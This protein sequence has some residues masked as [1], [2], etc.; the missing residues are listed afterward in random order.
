MPDPWKGCTCWLPT[1]FPNPLP[2]VPAQWLPRVDPSSLSTGELMLPCSAKNP[3]AP[4][5]SVSLF[6]GH[7]LSHLDESASLSRLSFW[8][9]SF[10]AHRGGTQPLGDHSNVRTSQPRCRISDSFQVPNQGGEPGPSSGHNYTVASPAEILPGSTHS[11]KQM[12]TH[13]DS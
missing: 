12:S 6:P 11:N 10:R 5:R 9:A 3:L 8:V 2:R 7:P 1:P 13:K 4:L